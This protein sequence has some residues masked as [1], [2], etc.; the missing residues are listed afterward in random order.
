MQAVS[1]SRSQNDSS[2]ANAVST[3]AAGAAAG[4][5][6]AHPLQ[7]RSVDVYERFKLNQNGQPNPNLDPKVRN[8]V[9]EHYQLKPSGL[10]NVPQGALND[11]ALRARQYIP[12]VEQLTQ[13]HTPTGPAAARPAAWEQAARAANGER[14]AVMNAVRARLSPEGLAFSRQ[15]KEEGKTYE[16]LASRSREKLNGEIQQGKY[17]GATTPEALEIEVNRRIVSSAGRANPHVN[18]MVQAMHGEGRAL[19]AVRG[20]GRAALVVGAVTDGVSLARAARQS[21]DS[22]DWHPVSREASRVAGGWVGAALAGAGAGA[23]A[24]SVVPGLGT[25]GGF[26]VGAVAG[27]IGYHLGS[28][29]AQAG[30]DAA[31][32]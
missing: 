32:Q 1:S 28:H 22:H 29:A 11:S 7:T 9:I 17:K 25:V 6:A 23:V 24:G 20:I 30:F 8:G 31:T 26:V 21:A 19:T 3:A 27:A 18:E 5:Y 15:L 12:T 14:N 13:K 4:R 2:A 10:N 16:D